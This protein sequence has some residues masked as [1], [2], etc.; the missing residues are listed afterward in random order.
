M[1]AGRYVG[2][3]VDRPQDPRLLR[4]LGR[5]VDDIDDAGARHAVIVRSPVAHGRLTRFDAT[6]VRD[7]GLAELVLGP[8]ELAG[9]ADPLPTKW[10]LPGQ[11]LTG[12]PVATT[13]VR[14]VGQ[15]LGVV[16]AAS[17]A[18]AEDAAERVLLDFEQLPA[19]CDVDAARAPG[20]PLLYPEHGSNVAGEIHFG[21]PLADLQAAIADAPH[22]VERELSI[23]RV[24]HS[25]LE[26]RGL[27]AEWIAGTEQLTVWMSSQASQVARHEL[28]ATL[29]LRVDQVRV[30]AADVGGSFGS[31]NT[32]YVD[33]AMVCAA[34][35]VLGRRVKWIEDRRENLLAT[36]QGRGQRARA[37]LALDADGRFAAL[38]AEI[39]G[40]L[41]AFA[42]QAG[43]GPFQV[44]G[45]AIEGPYRFATA[46]ATVSAVYTNLVPTGAYRGYG[47]QE[48]AW[49]R[50]RMIDEAAREL[51]V[52]PVELR[53][54]NLVTPAELPYTT[55]TSLTYDSGDYPSALRRAAELADTVR[56]GP[57]RPADQVRRGVGLA[58]SVEITGFAPS[59]LLEMFQIPWSGWESGR[60]RV[61][62]DGSVTVTSGVNAVGQG[63]ETALA[64]ITADELQVPID[65]VSVHLGDTATSSYSDLSSQASRSVTLAGGALVRAGARMRERM[66]GLAARA[67]GV[68]E[69]AVTWDGAVFGGGPG[70]ATLTW[71]E[72]A[73]RGWMGWGR[74]E[75]DRIQLEE[76]VDFDPPAITFAYSVAGAAVLAEID[77]GRVTVEGYWSVNDS[78]V[79]VNPMLAD[80]QI[81]GGIAQGLGV[82]LLEEVRHD[83]TTGQPLSTSLFDYLLPLPSDVPDPLIEHRCTPSTVIPG[84]FKGLGEGGCIPTPAAVGNALAAAVPEI[85]AEVVATPLA[86]STV[87]PLLVKAGLADG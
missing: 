47:M 16:V 38:H 78:G 30:V 17:R 23:Q 34:A 33:E 77:T 12:I 9:L 2:Q 86:P 85:A 31:K 36:Y 84:G 26:P 28:A 13:N 37:R 51:D 76:V 49:I 29:R 72:V 14:Y 68:A 25:P 50:E 58:C 44:A 39:V 52:S 22:V 32:L 15:P 7:T 73:H 20:A 6:A 10:R 64:Q 4:G 74:A 60:I 53:M 71:R 3:S 45:L 42:T 55:R 27:L 35:M 18:L 81:A 46:G 8:A 75:A 43:S 21:D 19:V 40:D 11:H 57:D 56:P 82:A 48:A 69:T 70:S 83:P 79:L 87:W 65:W 41:G 59:A 67:L 63:I 54:R 61:N 24:A 5:Y 1:Q 80:G 66:R 62:Q